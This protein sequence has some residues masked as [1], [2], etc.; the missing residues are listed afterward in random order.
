MIDT[1]ARLDAYRSQHELV[2]VFKNGRPHINNVELG[3]LRAQ[4]QQCLGLC[5]RQQLR[6]RAGC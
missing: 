2:F 1:A 6:Q 4:P 3:P 5:G